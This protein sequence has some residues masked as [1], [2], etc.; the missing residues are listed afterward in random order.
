MCPATK[1][2]DRGL[3]LYNDASFGT[4]IHVTILGGVGAAHTTQNRYR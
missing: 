2:K 3:S 4:G 1:E